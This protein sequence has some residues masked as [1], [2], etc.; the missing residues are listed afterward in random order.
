MNLYRFNGKLY[1]IA[2]NYLRKNKITDNNGFVPLDGIIDTSLVAITRPS[3]EK[4]NF[5]DSRFLALADIANLCHKNNITLIVV[6]P[7]SF[8]NYSF[9]ADIDAEFNRYMQQNYPD[10]KLLNFSNVENIPDL[11]GH[12]NWRDASHLNAVGA[13]K[14]TNHL[15]TVLKFSSN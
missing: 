6:L 11:K 7:P 2:F 8:N 3:K 5:K 9:E 1:N 13:A 4:F 10:I 14:F 15:N 12:E